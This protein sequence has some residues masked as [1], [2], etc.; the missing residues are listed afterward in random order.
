MTPKKAVNYLKKKNL[1]ADTCAANFPVKDSIVTRD[2]TSFDTAYLDTPSEGFVDFEKESAHTDTH[3]CKP[4][5]RTVQITKTI[6]RDSLIFRRDIARETALNNL[7]DKQNEAIREAKDVLIKDLKKIS[8]Q[9]DRISDL[10]RTRF[11]LW[12]L[13][14]A[15]VI[16]IF[17][18]PII[19]MLGSLVNPI[20]SF[21]PF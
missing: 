16:I 9:K 21:Y 17:R 5:V 15:L 20:K 6:R 2:T 11:K 12:L 13:I 1:L 19:S 3:R 7:L 18:K 8:E 4:I 14:A 10:K